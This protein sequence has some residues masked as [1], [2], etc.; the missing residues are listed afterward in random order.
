MPTLAMDFYGIIRS[1]ESTVAFLN[2]KGLLPEVENTA[3]CHKCGGEMKLYMKKERGKERAVLRC[4][5]KGCQTSRSPRQGNRFFHFTDRHGRLNSGLTLAQILEIT[6]FWCLQIPQQTAR[7]LTGRGDHTLC[8]WYNLC[9]DVPV[10]MFAKRGKMGGEGRVIQI[11]ECLLR[12]KRKFNRGRYLGRDEPALE[13]EEDEIEEEDIFTPRNY[14]TRIEGPWVFGMCEKQQD[15]VLEAR[16]FVVNRRDRETLLPIILNDVEK[17]SILHSD[18]WRA[19]RTL[20]QHGYTHKTVNHSEFFV[21]PESGA[22]TQRIETLWAPL[23][24]KIV[25]SMR[26]TSPELLPSYLAEAWWRLRHRQDDLFNV[27]LEDLKTA[28]VD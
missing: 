23:K 25:R 26:G 8:D 17:K 22:H 28:Y 9:R 27:F 24:H 4:R 10:A 6:F 13:L 5:R 2:E 12:G 3:V 16:Y 1:E 11:D 15:G 20:D 7:L 14:G 21:D 18:E 19:Y